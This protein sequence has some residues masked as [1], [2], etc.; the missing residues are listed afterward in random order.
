M[1]PFAERVDLWLIRYLDPI[2]VF[3]LGIPRTRVN[4][5]TYYG[6][7]LDCDS[8]FADIECDAHFSGSLGNHWTFGYPDLRVLI[9]P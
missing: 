3:S 6:P 2:T 1:F 9:D 4:R 7:R 8:I 5:G